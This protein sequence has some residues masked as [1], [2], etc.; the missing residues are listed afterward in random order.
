MHNVVE[1]LFTSSFL[2]TI[3]KAIK[4]EYI[5]IYIYIYVNVYCDDIHYDFHNE[6]RKYS[7]VYIS[8]ISHYSRSCISETPCKIYK[9]KLSSSE[10]IPPNVSQTARH[11]TNLSTTIAQQ[12]GMKFVW[13]P[14]FI[15]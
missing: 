4:P 10:L 9:V 5:Y 11:M 13:I 6:I 3:I 7:K 2:N 14:S 8:V 1:L 12:R 15:F